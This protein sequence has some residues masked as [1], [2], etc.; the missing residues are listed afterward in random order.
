MT[1]SQ[2]TQPLLR[3]EIGM[4]L[5]TS[6]NYKETVWLRNRS[7]VRELSQGW[8]PR[9]LWTVLQTFSLKPELFL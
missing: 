6:M 2:Y 3:P 5:D 7:R 9:K 4:C 1:L 8:L